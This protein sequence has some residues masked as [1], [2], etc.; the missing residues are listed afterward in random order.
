MFKL[1]KASVSTLILAT[2]VSCED[3]F[4]IPL[5]DQPNQVTVDNVNIEDLMRIRAQRT[6]VSKAPVDYSQHGDNWPTDTCLQGNEDDEQSPINLNTAEATESSDI[7]FELNYTHKISNATVQVEGD[8]SLVRVYNPNIEDND[9]RVYN[10]LNEPQLYHLSH[11]DWKVP[12]EHTINDRQLSAELQ[13]HHVQ[14]ATNREVV[15]SI[16][17][18]KEL[19][20]GSASHKTCFFDAFSFFEIDEDMARRAAGETLPGYRIEIPIKEFIDYLP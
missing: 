15:L 2:T 8:G 16:L 18:D 17:F 5:G 10:E 9:I 20:L 1:L 12:S 7:R 13:I 14:Y 11:M 19:A 3:V 4:Q 6:D